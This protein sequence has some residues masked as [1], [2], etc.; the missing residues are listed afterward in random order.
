MSSSEVDFVSRGEARLAYSVPEVAKLVGLSRRQIYV[1]FEQGRLSS[2]KVG[3][4]RLVRRSD[5]DRWL[6]AQR[7]L[8]RPRSRG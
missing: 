7:G 2:I 1:E 5:L 8:R 4:R 6:T 3:R